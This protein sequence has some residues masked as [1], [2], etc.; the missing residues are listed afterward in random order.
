MSRMLVVLCSQALSVKWDTLIKWSV[1][2]LKALQI[3]FKVLQYKMWQTFNMTDTRL[4]ICAYW[5]KEQ[6]MFW[7][8]VWLHYCVFVL[9]CV[10]SSGPVRQID[11]TLTEPINCRQSSQ[12]YGLLHQQYKHTAH[13]RTLL[14]KEAQSHTVLHSEMR[15][16]MC[17]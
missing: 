16:E 7:W 2:Y 5:Q 1:H 12:Y 8:G 17:S 11:S 10:C 15:Q 14:T 13:M 4:S 6:T 9:G 3:Q